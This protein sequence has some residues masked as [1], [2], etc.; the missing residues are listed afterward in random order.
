MGDKRKKVRLG[1]QKW[2]VL[3]GDGKTY[4]LKESSKGYIIWSRFGKDS[5]FSGRLAFIL[6]I[7]TSFNESILSCWTKRFS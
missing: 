2:M 6:K 7:S 5:Y 4:D 1:F 3:V